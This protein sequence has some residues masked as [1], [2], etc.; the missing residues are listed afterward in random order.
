LGQLYQLPQLV[1][2]LQ[3]AAGPAPDTDSAGPILIML[4]EVLRERLAGSLAD[5]VEAA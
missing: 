4:G 5:A 2:Q 1:Q 3:A